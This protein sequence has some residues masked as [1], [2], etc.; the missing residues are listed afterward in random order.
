MVGH[1]A[2]RKSSAR[3]A[4]PQGAKKAALKAALLRALEQ[5]LTTARAAHQAAVEGA[6]HE[7]ARPE[8]DKDTRGLEQSYLARG[9]AQRVSDLEAGLAAVTAMPLRALGDDD[10]VSVG[11]LV[12]LLEDGARRCF[13]VAPYGGGVELPAP[14]GAAITVL[15]ASSPLGR[16]LLGK[17]VGDECELSSAGQ[18]RTLEIA[19][20]E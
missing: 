17:Q 6:T 16:A 14:A 19:A 5:A 2:S 12:T 1:M 9:H 11:A 4:S 8:N 18:L 15:T 7:E 10:V 13:F 20:L 3:S